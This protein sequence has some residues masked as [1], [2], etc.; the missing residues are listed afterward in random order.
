MESTTDRKCDICQKYFPEHIFSAHQRLHSEDKFHP[1]DMCGK[2]FYDLSTLTNHKRTHIFI[3][4]CDL[5]EKAFSLRSSLVN[6]KRI[7]T[8]EKA[9]SCEICLKSFVTKSDLSWHNKTAE[10]LARKESDNIESSSNSNNIVDCGK[11]IKVE[12]IKEEINEEES[13]EVCIH[14]KAKVMILSHDIKVNVIKEE[15]NEK[16]SV[17]NLPFIQQEIGK[18]RN[19]A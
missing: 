14:K 8:C 10:H 17:E 1:C 2:A 18:N 12:T 7:H 5:C 11:V 15:I 19:K 6:H 13:V 9:Y 3:Y 16:E 4:S